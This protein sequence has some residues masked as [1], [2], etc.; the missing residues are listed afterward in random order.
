MKRWLLLTAIALLTLLVAAPSLAE[1]DESCAMRE[2]SQ[3]VYGPTC[4]NPPNCEVGP[5][6]LKI[7]GSTTQT[8]ERYLGTHDC[9]AWYEVWVRDC[10]LV[11]TWCSS[12]GCIGNG[13]LSN[14]GSWRFDGHTT[15]PAHCD[16]PDHPIDREP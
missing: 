1:T 13:F 16:P 3:L 7:I 8:T 6:L 2:S 5:C 15:T 11:C 9:K 4:L 12:T 14:C 10:D